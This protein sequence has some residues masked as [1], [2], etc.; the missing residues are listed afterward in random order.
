MTEIPSTA[1]AEFVRAIDSGVDEEAEAAVFRLGRGDEA[2]LC[3]MA[4]GESGDRRWWAVRALAEQGGVACGPAL[5]SALASEDSNLRATAAL[6]VG[7]VGRRE[8]AAVEPVLPALALLLEDP[9]GF[10]RQAAVDGFSLSGEVALP[11]LTQVLMESEHQG[12]RTR[13][14][15]ALR[16]LHTMKAAPVLF[17]CLN[18]EN[19]MV[20][21]YAYEA[22]DELGLLENLLFLP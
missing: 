17:R 18:D 14:A 1:V 22:L 2:T 21:T 7:H 9:D 6:A 5:V 10:T 11:T 15:S 20:R 19:A 13:A 4:L 3:A 16:N 8:P 12:A